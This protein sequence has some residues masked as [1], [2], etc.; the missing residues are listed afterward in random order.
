MTNLCQIKQLGLSCF[1]CCGFD[2][3]TKK[4]VLD[5]IKQNTI[6]FENFKN[7]KDGL[8]KYRD[9][10]KKLAEDGEWELSKSG[11]CYNL[12]VKEG[13]FVCP[14]H[15]MQNQGIDLR[16]DHCD[17][18]YNCKTVFIFDKWDKNKQNTFIEFIKSKKLSS[19]EYSKLMFKNKLLNEFENRIK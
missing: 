17:L 14:L 2:F 16:H 8:K 18:N 7:E 4:D 15:A 10:Y 3:T 11:I 6:D 13:A 12:I 1:G 5:T 19:Y 9:R